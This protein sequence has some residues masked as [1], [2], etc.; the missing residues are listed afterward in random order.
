MPDKFTK[1]KIISFLREVGVMS[2]AVNLNDR[3]ISSVVAFVVDNDYSFYFVTKRNTFKD[4]ALQKNPKLSLSVWEHNRMLVQAYGQVRELTGQD[5][6]DSMKAI[7]KSIG[8]FKNFWWPILGIKGGEHV[9]YKIQVEWLRVM[10]LSFSINEREERF[11]QII[12]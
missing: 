8:H 10:D 5:L 7:K 3:P 6:N 2:I 4:R 9:A 1:D 11:Y 12:S